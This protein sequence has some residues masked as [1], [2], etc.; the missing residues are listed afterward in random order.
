MDKTIRFTYIIIGSIILVV[1]LFLFF[2]SNIIDFER[3][4]DYKHEK[5]IRDS[6][7]FFRAIQ[8][9]NN[10]ERPFPKLVQ[11]EDNPDTPETVSAMV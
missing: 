1:F 7:K 6:E 2:P 3:G 11:R 5:I 9:S 4:S 10:L 8:S